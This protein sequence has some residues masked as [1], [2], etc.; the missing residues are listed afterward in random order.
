MLDADPPVMFILSRLLKR[1][2]EHRK[3][4][5]HTLQFGRLPGSKVGQHLAL[6]VIMHLTIAAEGSHHVLMAEVLRPRLHLLGRGADLLTQP[7]QGLAEAVRP[8]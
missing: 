4:T 5:A 2:S 8:V 7:R 3:V 1:S 6:P